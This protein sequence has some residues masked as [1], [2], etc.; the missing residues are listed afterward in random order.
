MGVFD[1][2][3]DALSGKAPAPDTTGKP[4][5]SK[6]ST[7]DFGGA[8]VRDRETCALGMQPTDGYS[9]GVDRAMGAHAD[10]AHPIGPAPK[11][12]GS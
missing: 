5:V 4:K 2:I 11:L 12:R 6:T 7:G 8:D 10:K 1:K 3:N 9:C